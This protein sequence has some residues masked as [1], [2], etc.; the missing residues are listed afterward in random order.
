MCLGY[1]D[2]TPQK[3]RARR[4]WKVFWQDVDGALHSLHFNKLIDVDR[5]IS[6][7]IPVGVWLNEKDFRPTRSNTALADDGTSYE[8][9]WHCYEQESD[10]P[11]AL[12]V[13]V[14]REVRCRKIVTTGR[15]AGGPVTV[16]K[17]VMV[18]PLK[19]VDNELEE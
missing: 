8:I 7:P 2:K 16:A 15:Q 3:H 10:P 14:V 5:Y 11:G 6:K 19:E 4:R 1:V 17:Y 13:T 9:G 12:R 18:L